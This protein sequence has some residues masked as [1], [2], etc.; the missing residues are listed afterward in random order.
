VLRVKPLYNIVEENVTRASGGS[1]RSKMSHV[2]VV[3]QKRR[4]LNP[5]HP[6]QARMLLSQGKAAVLKRF[7][8]TLIL[9]TEREQPH[10][11]PLRIKLDPGS[12]TTGLA[13]VNDASGEVVFAAEITHRGQ[14]IKAALDDRR[15][16]RRSRRQRKTRYRKARFANRRRK[17]GWISPSLKSRV[18]NVVAWV[19][20]LRTVCNLAA[21]S[22]ELVKF[23]LQ[24]REHPEITGTQYQ[25]GTLQGYEI[26]E[27]LLHKWNR[28]CAYCD[29]KDKPLQVE[30]I[31]PR[32]NGGTNRVSNLCLACEPCNKA[33]GTLAIEVFMAKKPDVLKRIL[34]Q[35]KT[36]L[37]DAAAVNTTRW[38]LFEHLK[39]LGLPVECGSGGLT[40]YNRTLREL[41]KEHWIDACCVGKSTPE[42]V[43]VKDMIPL[44]IRAEGHGRRQM[45]LM[46]KHGFPR[47]G[48]KQAKSIQGFQTGNIVRAVVKKGKKIGTYTGRI[49]VRSSGYFNITTKQATIQGIKYADCQSVHRSDGYSYQQGE[50]H[51]SHA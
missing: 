20:R 28:K 30:H 15:A 42:H 26:R 12:K 47:T 46:S 27:Y 37:K 36:P 38:L 1:E 34:D 49:A 33:K 32:A 16:A 18:A 5:V 7:P 40:A 2:F 45:C 25:Q 22:M 48:P 3:D 41:P 43:L 24:K 29:A 8:F 11:Q 39:A 4:P 44:L 19:K 14:A 13:I 6:G 17:A 35:A 10:V 23:D 51:S 31:F 21:I 50:R 9:K